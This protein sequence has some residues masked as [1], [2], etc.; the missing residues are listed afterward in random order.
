MKNS[1]EMVNSLLQR[2]EQ[3][4]RHNKRKKKII[5]LSA[6]CAFCVCCLAVM[7]VNM[8]EDETIIVPSATITSSTT[9]AQKTEISLFE[10]SAPDPDTDSFGEDELVHVYVTLEGNKFYMQLEESDYSKYGIDK[11]LDETDFGEKI[12]TITE[13]DGQAKALPTPC[14]QE[15][16]LAGCEV[17]YYTP[18]NSEA[19]IIVKGNGHCS[20]FLFSSFS[21]EGHSYKENYE[22]FGVTS[23]EDIERIDYSVRKP[24]G[25]LIETVREG[26]V[27]NLTDLD[28]FMNI[29]KKLTAYVHENAISGDPDWLI[30]AREEYYKSSKENQ[31]IIE[32][33]VVLKNG[34]SIPFNYQPNLGTGYVWDHHFLSEEDNATMIELFLG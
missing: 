16:T 31:I 26:S 13:I 24:V 27:T 7:G 6:T 4:T 30:T 25:T 10:A 23:L 15:P 17:F 5:S 14:S 19:V 22:I 28:T 21:E 3:Y 33:K 8:T 2:R 20:L 11:T 12:G 32:A 34:L 29:T 9:S 18:V 1:N